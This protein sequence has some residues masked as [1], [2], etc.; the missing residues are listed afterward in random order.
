MVHVKHEAKSPLVVS[1]I[2]HGNSS[3][4]IIQWGNGFIER[5]IKTSQMWKKFISFCGNKK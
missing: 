2:T 1:E 3:L 4:K 5:K